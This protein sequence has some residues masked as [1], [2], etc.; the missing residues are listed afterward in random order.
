MLSVSALCVFCGSSNA[1]PAVYRDAAHKLGK[2]LGACGM[3]L[4]Y[5]GGS[6]GLMGAVANATLAAGGKVTGIIP[7]HILAAEVGHVGLTELIVVDTMHQR[8]LKMFEMSDAFVALPGGVGTLDETIEIL[9]WRTL[10]LHD[11]PL[12]LINTAGYWTPLINLLE[13]TV[14]NHFS[15]TETREFYS[16]AANVD[17]L[18]GVL[19]TWSRPSRRSREDVI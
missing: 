1:V 6:V 9:S 15:T 7:R 16:V 19:E 3:H 4:V 10:G 8:K 11:K 12:V 14:R 5:G 18:L 13:H 2:I 17:D